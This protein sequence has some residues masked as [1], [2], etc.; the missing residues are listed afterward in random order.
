MSL[1]FHYAPMSSATPTHWALEELGVPYEKVRLD[2][3]AR[4]QDRPAFRALNP[5][6]KVPLL[7]HD[8]VPLFE[9]VAILL[10]PRVHVEPKTLLYALVFTIAV[11]GG[12]SLAAY[13]VGKRA[14]FGRDTQL[15][16][17]AFDADRP[18]RQVD[19]PDV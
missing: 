10:H 14:P 3:R 12:K 7:V 13:I 8:G 16:E 1:V 18:V 4:D 2:L 5:N 9:S 11:L 6:G 17:R 19:S 15:G